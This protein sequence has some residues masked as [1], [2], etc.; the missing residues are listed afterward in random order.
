M[1]EEE[2]YEV[3]SISGG[4]ESEMDVKVENL[5]DKSNA[6]FDGYGRKN[7]KYEEMGV[8]ETID[9]ENIKIEEADFEIN[10]ISSNINESEIKIEIP[11]TKLFYI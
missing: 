1:D 9:E 4:N 5:D 7:E 3:Q 11:E 2:D 6:I 10:Y 8:V